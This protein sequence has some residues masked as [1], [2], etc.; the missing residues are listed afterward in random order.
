MKSSS[1]IRPCDEVIELFGGAGGLTWGWRRAGFRPVVSIDKDTAAA[2]THEFNFREEHTLTL[3]RDLD[4]FG[5]G[6]LEE[7]LGGRPDRL[8]AVTGGPPCQGWSK[9]GRGKLRSLHGR[10]NS[11]LHD[12]RNSLYRQFISYVGHFRPPVCVMENV[13]G[14]LNLEERNVAEEVVIN[15][16]EVGYRATYALVNA[17][18][19]GVPQ[20]RK[21]LIFLGVRNDLSLTLDAADL[22]MYAPTFLHGVAGLPGE[23][24]VRRAI[25]DLP[26][27]SHGTGE[28]PQP[29]RR[30][31][32]AC[33]R[34]VSLMRQ[35]SNGLI[36]DHVCR[37]HNAQDLEAFALMKEGGIYADLPDHLKRYRDDI[38]P[39]KYRK[40]RWQSVSGTVTAHLAKDCYTHIHPEQ[41]RTISI[42]EAARLQSFPDDFRFSGNMGDRFRQIGNAV[43]PLMAWGIAEYVLDRL[44]EWARK[45]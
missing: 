18:W 43:P 30:A 19:F 32:R 34:Y 39:D 4:R 22:M 16:D 11:L 6:D 42:R 28:D 9:V 21:R 41:F 25:S 36:T 37:E 38:F 45:R 5:P 1:R 29:Y 33:S 31:T 13:P 12:P 2:K 14:M 27:I 3:N 7:L 23:T 20:D 40:L 35:H 26:A 24:T 8:L 10:A 15:F 17:R 44:K